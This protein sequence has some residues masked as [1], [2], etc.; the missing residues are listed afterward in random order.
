MNSIAPMSTPAGRLAGQ[1]DLGLALHLAGQHDLLL[2]AAGEIGGL[3]PR[4]G[5]P[6]VVGRHLAGEIARSPARVLRNGPRPEGRVAVDAQD[7]AFAGL[8]GWSPGRPGAGPPAR[9]S[10]PG[11]RMRLGIERL[12][13]HLAAVDQDVARGERPHAGERL[14]QLGL[15]VAGDPGEPGDL[16]RPQA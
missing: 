10:G 1:H 12:R 2:V 9:G 15:A 8:E 7:G 6:D 5:G 11:A 16:A 13:R 4:R 14:Q 3:Q